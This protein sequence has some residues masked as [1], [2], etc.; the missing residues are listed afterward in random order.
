MFADSPRCRIAAAISSLLMLPPQIAVSSSFGLLEQSSS[1]LGTA[2]AGTA[3]AADDATTLFYNPAGL[4]QLESAEVTLVASG[5]YIESSFENAGSQPAL[6]QQLGV[7]GGNAGGWNA[8]P[9]AYLALPLSETFAAGLAFNVPFG[10]S[11]DYERGWMGR[12]QALR[13]EIETFNFNPSIAWQPSESFSV[14]IGLNH[15]R[16]QAELTN[17]VNYSAVVAQGLQQLVAAGQLSPALVPTLLG[18]NA[19]LEGTTVLRGHDTAW[20]FNVG[21]LFIAP[22]GTRIGLSYR[23]ALDYEIEGSVRF[24]PPT[25]TNPVG[26]G[27]IAAAGTPGA[28][29]ASGRALVD[30]KLPDSAIVSVQHPITSKLSLLADAAWTGWSSIQE[31]RVR[32][33]TGEVIS[34]T[35]EEWEDTWRFAVGATYELHPSLLLRAGVAVDST[36]V[37]GSTRTARLPDADRTWVALGARWRASDAVEINAGYAHLFS[38]DVRLQQNAGSTAANGFLIGEQTSGVDIISVQAAYKF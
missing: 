23:S 8:I 2:F 20:G 21:L 11:L 6:G 36:P 15:Q 3:A 13:S 12:F 31:L 10:L 9:S 5:I 27:I 1:R 25:A 18:A 38:D 32:R 4:T 19:G 16:A 22:T 37:P 34:V 33:D 28:P 14:G 35:P 29:L 7:E 17:A 26:S 30:L 24:A